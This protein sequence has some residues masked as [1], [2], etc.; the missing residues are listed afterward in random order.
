MVN[1]PESKQ[2]PAW[3][4]PHAQLARTVNQGLP[5]SDCLAFCLEATEHAMQCCTAAHP[6]LG[7]K[8]SGVA[9]LHDGTPFSM[10]GC[11]EI[12]LGLGLGGW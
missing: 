3:L 1:L 10:Q 6:H 4:N 7:E 9:E 11:I 8:K 5:A 2:M 12:G